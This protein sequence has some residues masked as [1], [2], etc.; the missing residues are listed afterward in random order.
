MIDFNK[1]IIYLSFIFFYS[2]KSICRFFFPFITPELF[3]F[4][5]S[6]LGPPLEIILSSILISLAYFSW[7]YKC[8]QVFLMNKRILLLAEASLVAQIVKSPPAMQKTQICSLGWKDPCRREWLSTPVFWPGE[9]HGQRS[10]AGYSPWHRTE[11][12]MTE[13]LTHTYTH[14]LLATVC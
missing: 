6:C 1:N 12:D 5:C 14:N 3:K 4:T 2:K 10:L 11:S 8:I 7:E 9:F 13:L